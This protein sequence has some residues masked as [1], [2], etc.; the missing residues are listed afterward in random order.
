MLVVFL[1]TKLQHC[2][3]SAMEQYILSDEWLF[4]TLLTLRDAVNLTVVNTGEAGVNT[5]GPPQETVINGL[6]TWFSV[7]GPKMA[8]RNVRWLILSA[9]SDVK[10]ASTK[11]KTDQVATKARTD[12]CNFLKKMYIYFYPN[13]S[14]CL[15]F[16]EYG[17][18]LVGSANVL[19]ATIHIVRRGRKFQGK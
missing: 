11:T 16:H 15:I 10:S 17:I 18:W 7:I 3:I 14:I 13:F 12:L 9:C 19:C 8:C 6:F 4:L 1:N 5:T 2:S